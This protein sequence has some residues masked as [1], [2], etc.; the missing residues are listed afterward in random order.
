MKTEDLAARAAADDAAQA[1]GREPH[2]EDVPQ[3]EIRELQRQL[4][5]A[6]RDLD[7]ARAARERGRKAAVMQEEIE[8]AKRAARE[9]RAVADAEAKYGP[10][11]KGIETVE[12]IDGLLIVRK[13]DGIK[14]RKW[15]D[16][17]GENI[18]SSA[19]RQITRPCVVYPPL[20][21]FDRMMDERPISL[22]AATTAVLK[23]SGLRVKELGGK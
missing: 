12:T 6:L 2:A 18:N 10:I 7:E 17:H 13:P 5:D 19:C 14:V 1:E 11:G 23:L 15:Q 8:T 22:T 9:Q 20:D 16:Q 4:D 3:A 21:E